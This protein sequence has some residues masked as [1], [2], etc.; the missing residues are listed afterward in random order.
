MPQESKE[1]NIVKGMA[2]NVELENYRLCFLKNGTDRNIENLQWLHQQNL[3][4]TN[5]IFYAMDG[6]SIAAIYTALPVMLTIEGNTVPALQSIDTMTDINHRGKGLFIKLASALYNDATENKFSLVYGFPNENSASGFFKKLKWISFGEAPFLIKPINLSYFFKKILNR[7]KQTDFSSSNHIFDAPE[8]VQLKQGL[9][10]KKID[11]F[12]SGYDALWQTAIKSFKVG[13]NRNAA[14][15]NWRYVDKPDE[16][17]YRY[18][19]YK[20]NNLQAVIVFAI[21]KKHDGKIGYIM[22][23]IFSPGD[24]K[25]GKVLLKFAGRMFKSQDTDAVLA[26]CFEHSFNYPTYKSAGYYKL[27]LKL[28][29]QKLFLGVRAFDENKRSLIEN[30]QNWYISYSD[31]DTV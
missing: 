12:D 2:D 4:G 6:N 26:W 18:G 13:I 19:L 22:E 24:P 23:L 28:R 15:M 17:Y 8:S 20:N 7:K 1:Y 29:P 9:V 3:A 5:T 11:G 14:Y 16:H 27:P 30:P 25:K 31:S 10:I 21:K